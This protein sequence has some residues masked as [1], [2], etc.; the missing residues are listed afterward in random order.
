MASETISFLKSLLKYVRY[1][2]KPFFLGLTFALLS[3]LLTGLGAWSI[4]P[5]FNYVFV[6]KHYEYFKFVPFYLVL[7]F[8][9]IGICSLLQAYFMKSLST[10]VI[11]RIRLELFQK[12]LSLPYRKLIGETSGQTVSKVINDTSQIEPILGETSQILIKESFTVL[13]L[14]GVAF[15]QRW[16]LTLITL[17]T[18]PVI[19]LGTKHLGSKT[20]RAR[21]LTQAS[22]GELTHRMSEILQG[23]RE[24][25]LAASRE[26]LLRFFSKEL[27]RFYKLSL[28]ITK[29][30]EASKSL[31]DLMT[32]LGGA[33]LLGYGGVLVIRGD[34]TPGAFIS[35]VTAILLVFNPIRK[36]SRAYTGLKEAQGAWMRL[37]EVFRLEEERGG[38]LIAHPPKK[39][40]TFRE[41]S[42]RYDEKLPFALKDISLF[43]PVNQ[44]V[45]LVG[46]SGAGKSTLISLL[47]RFYDPQRGEI[48]LDD[49]NIVE[50]NLESLRS[51]FGLVWQE[52]FLFNL[53]IWEN[54]ILAK[55]EATKE[56]ILEACRMAQALEFIS[57]LPKGFDTV[58]GEEGFTLSG[59][60]KQ[61]LALARVFLKK[62]PI[63]ILDEAT[64]QLDAL[65][66]RAI[67]MA[68]QDLKGK[69]TLVVIAHRL[70][71]IQRA[72]IIVVMDKGE[73][74]AKG[75]HKELLEISPL[76]R[77]LYQTFVR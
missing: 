22:T 25:K 27:E 19:I 57:T 66:E 47:P 18:L 74:V 36:L 9:L 15:Y 54:L 4:K 70:S 69:C 23:I 38:N 16:D 46:P 31:V 26:I 17:I 48:L 20:R 45:A 51:L 3:S 33:L 72:D 8:S 24:I 50:F 5:I 41:V 12:C 34:L 35:V 49:T 30:R 55:P 1:Y 7:L 71:T 10:G 39:G 67:E 43:I 68:L 63:I 29:Y 52:P 76:Y 2:L 65:T 32:G 37:E 13:V 11:N 21:R 61:R 42:F 59:G 64:S 14:L 56:E 62:P 44:M 28:K 6:E 58:L 77:E 40:I 60:Q 75:K 53:S 73:I